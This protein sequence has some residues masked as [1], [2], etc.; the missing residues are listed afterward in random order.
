[1]K[2]LNE[3]NNEKDQRQKRI[4]DILVKDNNEL[5]K[6]KKKLFWFRRLEHNVFNPASKVKL[7]EV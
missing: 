7:N 1:M 4:I 5:N 2:L 3:A 6:E